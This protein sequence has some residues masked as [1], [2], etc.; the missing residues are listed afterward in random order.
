MME[1]INNEKLW[2]CV[3]DVAAHFHGAKIP[4]GPVKMSFDTWAASDE[5]KQ[6]CGD[7]LEYLDN[8]GKFEDI[9]QTLLPCPHCGGSSSDA[10]R[11]VFMGGPAHTPDFHKVECYACGSRIE[12]STLEGAVAAWNKR[13]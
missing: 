11:T 5:A 2:R 3:R 9:Q 13:P 1:P 7:A 8:A 6:L 4:D 10:H 12:R